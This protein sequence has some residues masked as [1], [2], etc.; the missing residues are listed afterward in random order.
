MVFEA[1][2]QS[3]N[4]DYIYYSKDKMAAGVLGA[5]G[6]MGEPGLIWFCRQFDIFSKVVTLFAFKQLTQRDLDR[7]LVTWQ[8]TN[9]ISA[10][11]NSCSWAGVAITWPGTVWV[12]R[13]WSETWIHWLVSCRFTRVI[14]YSLN[15]IT[16]YKL[17]ICRFYLFF[18]EC[19]CRF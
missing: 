6:M 5:L 1:R 11:W 9:L 19:Q 8:D 14:I 12:G 2:K 16:T 4:T 7:N 15:Y 3:M 10:W 13:D 18:W 17:A